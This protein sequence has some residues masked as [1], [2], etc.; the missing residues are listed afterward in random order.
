MESIDRIEDS[1]TERE[2]G[3]SSI[4]N[5]YRSTQL[6]L[7]RR[8]LLSNYK[9]KVSLFSHAKSSSPMECPRRE[10][11]KKVNVMSYYHSYFKLHLIFVY[12]QSIMLWC[13]KSAVT[14]YIYKL[15]VVFR[16]T[17]GTIF[18]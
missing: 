18:A 5:H 4:H 9:S 1:H 13:N 12:I 15:T 2:R 16:M 10:H 7:S 17:T 11:V 3:R 6:S 8:R 14:V